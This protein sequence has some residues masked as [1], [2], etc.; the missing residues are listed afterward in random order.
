VYRWFARLAGAASRQSCTG[1]RLTLHG[2]QSIHRYACCHG[3]TFHYGLNLMRPPAPPV[4]AFPALI[5]DGARRRTPVYMLTWYK[6]HYGLNFRQ[7][8]WITRLTRGTGVPGL[9]GFAWS[10][11]LYKPS[12]FL[13]RHLTRQWTVLLLRIFDTEISSTCCATCCELRDS[14][15]CILSWKIKFYASIRRILRM[16]CELFDK[17]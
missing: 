17:K 16:F 7:A 2:T 9:P 6:F 15:Y 8:P 4:A 1:P 5:L 12:Q 14:R 10:Y 11:S 13:S 3:T